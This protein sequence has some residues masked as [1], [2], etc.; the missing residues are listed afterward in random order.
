MLETRR[1]RTELTQAETE[2]AAG[3]YSSARQRLAALA[4]WTA[5]DE[6]AYQLGVC[7]EKLGRNEAA[8]AA[9][10]RVSS[11]SVRAAAATVGRSRLLRA[12]G[13]LSEAEVV[14]RDAWRPGDPAVQ[15]VA[16]ELETIARIEGR[17]LD[18]RSIIVQSWYGSND[19]SLVIKRLF[20][21]DEVT[22]MPTDFIRQALAPALE[23]DDDRAWLGQAN[24]ALWEGRLD[25]ASRLLAQCRKRNP[26]DQPVWVA[27]LNLAMATGDFTLGKAAVGHIRSQPFLGAEILHI[28]AW[29]AGGEGSPQREAKLLEATLEQ[30]PG[31]ALARDRL[32]E[33]ALA[34]GQTDRAQQLRL[35]QAEMNALRVRYA[36]L[37]KAD[38][39]TKHIDELLDLATR[40]G[41]QI[42][43][44][45]WRLIKEGKAA[46][47][48]LWPDMML[49]AP[50]TLADVIGYDQFHQPESVALKSGSERGLPSK[51]TETTSIMPSLED[52]AEARGLKFYHDNGHTKRNPPPTE[53]MCGGVAL[54]DYDGDGWLDVYAVQGGPFPPTGSPSTEG[55]RLFRNLGSGRFEDVTDRSNI[56]GFSKGYGHGVTVGDYDNDG[57]PDLFVTR[58][59]GYALYRNKGNGTFEDVTE[60]TGLGGDRDWPTSAAF[61]DL[62]NDGDLDLYVCHYLL[63]QPE[64]VK[65]CEHPEA[66]SRHDC[67]PLDF[68]KLPDHVFRNDA[69]RFVDVTQA[70]GF[71]DPNGRGLGVVAAHLDDDDQI[72]LYVANDMT[73]NYLFRNL[74][75]FRFEEVGQVAGVAASADGLFKSGMGV[76]CGDLDGD[77][78]LDLAVTNYFGES[79]SFS[80]NV[81]GGFFVDDTVGIGLQSPSRPLL[82]F[83][84]AFF[85][86]NNDG[87]LDLLSVNGHVLD[88]RPRT[89][90]MMPMQLL[91]GG[92]GGR[93]SD[94]TSQAGKALGVPRL[95][96]GLAIGDID[97]DGREDALVLAQNEPLICL[98]NETSARDHFVTFELKGVKSNRDAVGARVK[99]S[100]SGRVRVA[101]RTGGGS[102]QSA[103][104]PRLQFGLGGASQVDWVE[105]RWPSGQVDR[106]EKLAVDAA[107]TIRE[108][109]RQATTLWKRP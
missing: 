73:A 17:K 55:D 71:V 65:R 80:R 30:D 33:L 64:N 28:Q 72:D 47:E 103:S 42:D 20:T 25:D 44:R 88:G 92:P 89:P 14:L 50:L 75:G 36:T 66:P 24:L 85:D 83:G 97:N 4:A 90:W 78:R 1:Q 94:V 87:W 15:E 31:N 38:E 5:Q 54:L 109:S 105:V 41:R 12:M 9:W 26:D 74:G 48:A 101:E 107:Y 100:A 27:T 69:G 82:G 60:P 106:F 37:L 102:Y 8:L 7:E 68:P 96:R 3:R 93:L 62:D 56:G 61:A 53:A 70:A 6:V 10:G 81:G 104:G 63:Y 67:M 21:L 13:R 51:R 58:W 11:G 98:H 39:R 32:A 34:S 23:A 43:A 49:T 22:N 95:G 2:I 52:D 45:G 35:K 84:I 57:H 29:L 91:T 99:L 79:T 59:H 46:S 77:G 19:P 76:A 18:A 86:A 40:I 108:G 16:R